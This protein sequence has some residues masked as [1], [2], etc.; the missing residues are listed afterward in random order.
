M[1]IIAIDR[2]GSVLRPAAFLAQINRNV[3]RFLARPAI[4]W[5][6]ESTVIVGDIP[7]RP[8]AFMA[9]LAF[10]GIRI[11]GI[12]HF[13]GKVIPVDARERVDFPSVRFQTTAFQAV[14]L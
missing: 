10:V 6:H 14:E 8:D 13:L 2:A 12:K 11:V 1:V 7:G 4:A 5:P 9:S 3:D